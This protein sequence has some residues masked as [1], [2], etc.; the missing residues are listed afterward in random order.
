VVYTAHGFH[1]YEHGSRV[2]NLV[3]LTAER[4]AG[5]WTDRLVVINDEDYAAA[6]NHG[7]VPRHRLVL[8]PGIGIDT[9][10][11][12]ASRVTPEAVAEARARSGIEPGTPFFAVVGEL[13]IRKRP[14]DVVAAL[15]RMKHRE[16]HLVLLG[17]GPELE[18][19]ETAIRDADVADRVHIVGFLD[20]VRPSMVASTALVLASRQEGLPRCIMEAL[21]L[22][23]PVV[24]TDAR[25]S[26]DLVEP[27]A[28]LIVPV[29]DVNALARAMDRM[30]DEPEAAREMAA[31]GRERMVDRYDLAIL[32]AQHEALY[33]E[34]L[35]ER[36]LSRR[37][38][39]RR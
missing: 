39:S 2:T 17:D 1:F 11:Y 9:D 20:D 23:V 12:A 7:V 4:V 3:F 24:A 15:G 5:R 8:M 22:E 21:S 35:A 25:G 28:G 16:P 26:P 27:D 6:L 10:W 33:G 38:A 37:P 32:I 18:R 29:G 30:L 14:F 31:R 36:G 34:L 19:V 13:S